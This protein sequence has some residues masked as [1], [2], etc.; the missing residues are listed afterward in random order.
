M[1]TPF[2]FSAVM[3]AF[4]RE[5]LKNSLKHF[6]G[7]FRKAMPDKFN[8]FLDAIG[9]ENATSLREDGVLFDEGG[10]ELTDYMKATSII[11]EC[12]DCNPAPAVGMASPFSALFLA[13]YRAVRVQSKP[14]A[15]EW[16]HQRSIQRHW[17]FLSV[18]GILKRLPPDA[19]GRRGGGVG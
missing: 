3:Y 15:N 2:S 7:E 5:D 11:L 14:A 8:L 13:T 18:C 1:E 19:L 12:V 4:R 6:L 16:L 10:S 17:K 9:P